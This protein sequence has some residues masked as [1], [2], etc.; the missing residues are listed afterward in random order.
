MTV[1]VRRFEPGA[2]G[3]FFFDFLNSHGYGIYFISGNLYGVRSTPRGRFKRTHKRDV[4]K[5]VDR[6]RIKDGLEPIQIK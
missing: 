1:K 3:T 2:S 6:L 4:L 5:L